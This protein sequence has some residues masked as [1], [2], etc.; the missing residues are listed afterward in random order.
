MIKHNYTKY[1]QEQKQPYQ[2]VFRKSI[3]QFDESNVIFDNIN[4]KF[5]ATN[6]EFDNY[7]AKYDKTNAT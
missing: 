6:P 7:N 3:K 5:D 4:Q 2:H 1:H